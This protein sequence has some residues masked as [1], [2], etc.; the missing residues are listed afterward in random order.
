MVSVSSL[1]VCRRL[2]VLCSGELP[3]YRLVLSA[4]ACSAI[5]I[6]FSL[7]RYA[8]VLI[9]KQIHANHS[10]ILQMAK[11]LEDST[12]ANDARQSVLDQIS[13]LMQTQPFTF[14]RCPTC[15][16]VRTVQPM[17]FRSGFQAAWTQRCAYSRFAQENRLISGST[18][19]YF[20]CYAS[21]SFAVSALAVAVYQLTRV[22]VDD[23]QEF[24]TLTPC[25]YVNAKD[26]PGIPLFMYS[27]HDQV[28]ENCLLL[29]QSGL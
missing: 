21:R 9:E 2:L 4:T 5:P 18:H 28:G 10:D 14:L 6:L 20:G 8:L 27:H 1:H 24:C 29:I 22:P 12:E 3:C 16:E 25:E 26:Q 7:S 19:W 11:E 13:Q 15:T 23:G 17:R